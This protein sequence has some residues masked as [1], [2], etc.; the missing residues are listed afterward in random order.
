MGSLGQ[1]PGIVDIIE[2]S[3]FENITMLHASNGARKLAFPQSASITA[4]PSQVSRHGRDQMSASEESATSPGRTCKLRV[5]L[6]SSG[7]Q[8]LTNNL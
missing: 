2:D 4:N 3:W 7:F 5:S 8:R 6:P 1:Y